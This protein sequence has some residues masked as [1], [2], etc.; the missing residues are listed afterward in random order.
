[1]SKRL[2]SPYRSGR[3]PDWLKMKKPDSA[4][5]RREAK[6]GGGPATSAQ[7]GQSSDAAEIVGG[8]SLAALR[9]GRLASIGQ[10]ERLI[11][12]DVDAGRFH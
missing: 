9:P 5:V 11:G 6:E 10:V 4:A 7:E 2:G 1:M 3:S 8:P 12:A